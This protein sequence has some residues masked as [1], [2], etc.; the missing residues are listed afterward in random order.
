VAW[1]VHVAQDLL[2]VSEI[3]RKKIEP[4]EIVSGISQ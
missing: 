1:Q 4:E 2:E 3:G